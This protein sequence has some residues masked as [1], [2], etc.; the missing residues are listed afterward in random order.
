LYKF[1]IPNSGYLRY[2]KAQKIEVEYNMMLLIIEKF[3]TDI[4]NNKFLIKPLPP[5][6]FDDALDL[7]AKYGENL[8][9]GSLDALHAAIVKNTNETTK[10]VTSDGGKKTES[11]GKLTELCKELSIDTFNPEKAGEIY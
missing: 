11:K 5:N 1:I 4:D 6:S 7:V 2:I 9:F 3:F 8:Q 10:I